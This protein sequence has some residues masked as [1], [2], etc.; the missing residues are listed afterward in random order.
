MRPNLYKNFVSDRP[1]QPNPINWDCEEIIGK[2]N[3]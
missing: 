1:F 3:S 2:I